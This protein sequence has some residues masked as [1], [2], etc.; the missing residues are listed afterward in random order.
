LPESKEGLN[1]HHNPTTPYLL[2]IPRAGFFR[3][4]AL[5]IDSGKRNEPKTLPYFVGDSIIRA[6]QIV[7]QEKNIILEKY[8]DKRDKFFTK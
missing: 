6:Q 2:R 4:Q 7:C 8:F 1:H 5:K 3:R